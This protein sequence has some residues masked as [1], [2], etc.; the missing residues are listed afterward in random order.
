MRAVLSAWFVCLLL[1]C[2]KTVEPTSPHALSDAEI[3]AVI[4]GFHAADRDLDSPN[5]R[6]FG[7]ARSADGHVYVCGWMSSKKDGYRT[8]ERPFFGTLFAGQ[9]VPE[10]LAKDPFETSKVLRECREHGVT[11]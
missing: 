5:F 10:R 11:I 1:G 9:F 7:A 4:D 3:R 2:A 6:K 8:G